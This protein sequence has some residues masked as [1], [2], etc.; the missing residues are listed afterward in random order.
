[1]RPVRRCE[2]SDRRWRLTTHGDA[3]REAVTQQ[4]RVTARPFRHCEQSEAISPFLPVRVGAKG[5]PAVL[6]MVL[7]LPGR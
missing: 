2:Q 1:M 6:H 3:G 4:G 5:I 7:I